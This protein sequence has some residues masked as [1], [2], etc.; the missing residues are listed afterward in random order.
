MFDKDHWVRAFGDK[1]GTIL[2]EKCGKEKI[3]F[4]TRRF[5]VVSFLPNVPKPTYWILINSVVRLIQ[6][7][8]RKDGLDG[9]IRISTKFCTVETSA[10]GEDILSK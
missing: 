1:Y 6:V 4:G 3:R 8:C 7:G 5:D 10:D 2:F 9:E